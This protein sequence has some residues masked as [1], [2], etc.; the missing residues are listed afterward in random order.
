MWIVNCKPSK[1]IDEFFKTSFRTN[2]SPSVKQNFTSKYIQHWNTIGTSIFTTVDKNDENI[3]PMP[4]NVQVGKSTKNNWYYYQSH[5]LTESESENS[6]YRSWVQAISEG[7]NTKEQF[8][9][10]NHSPEGSRQGRMVK[11]KIEKAVDEIFD[12]F[13]GELTDEAKIELYKT[14]GIMVSKYDPQY[15]FELWTRACDK[16]VDTLIDHA[17]KN[18]KPIGK[19]TKVEP[20]F[21][22]PHFRKPHF[23]QP[24]ILAMFESDPYPSRE[25]CAEIAKAEGVSPRTVRHWLNKYRKHNNLPSPKKHKPL[26]ENVQAEKQLIA[27]LSTY[28]DS[29]PLEVETVIEK[30][31]HLEV[32]ERVH[33]VFEKNPYPSKQEID[34]I[35][36]NENVT[37]KTVNHWL[38]EYRQR[39]SIRPPNRGS[40]S[41]FELYPLL[42]QQYSLDPFPSTEDKI[43]LM[44]HTGLSKIQITRSFSAR[45]KRDGL[46]SQASQVHLGTSLS[47]KFPELDRQ[48]KINPNPTDD[49]ISRF[50]EITGLSRRQ[51]EKYFSNR[52]RLE[53][54]NQM[55]Q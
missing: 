27:E 46:L 26:S 7:L 48:F 20:H 13:N 6:N 54:I 39:N 3:F 12:K 40:R 45:R 17:V 1:A 30:E 43:R 53:K 35:A 38:T 8:Y 50:Q 47:K 29:K 4:E 41:L 11:P 18:P 28:D 24:H 16:M 21:R 14:H 55:K 10:I 19:K 44:E 23:L 34:E 32:L 51:I 42:D 36:Q 25:E 33:A 52:S 15:F 9:F 2:L 31:S 22:K 37:A 49:E 5:F